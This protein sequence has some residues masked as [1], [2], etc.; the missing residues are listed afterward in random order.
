MQNQTHLRFCDFLSF[1]GSYVPVQDRPMEWPSEKWHWSHFAIFSHFLQTLFA[2]MNETSGSMEE[3][4]SVTYKICVRFAQ[5]LCWCTAALLRT[6]G[7]VEARQ[8]WRSKFTKKFLFHL[9]VIFFTNETVFPESACLARSDTTVWL[10]YCVLAFNT[11]NS[12]SLNEFSFH[13]YF[14]IYNE[15]VRDLLRPASPSGEKRTLK[16]REHPKSGPYVQGKTTWLHYFCGGRE[17]FLR[18]FTL[19]WS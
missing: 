6:E 7:S 4:E 17:S 1:L 16:V 11:P 14:E 10:N 13:S 8:P 15:K 19:K 5:F 9:L 18:C 12:A 3:D 2:Q